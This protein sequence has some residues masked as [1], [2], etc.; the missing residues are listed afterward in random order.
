MVTN[1]GNYDVTM[2][3]SNDKHFSPLKDRETKGIEQSFG[4][5]LL[6]LFDNVNQKETKSKEL[7]ELAIVSPEEVNVHEVMIAEEEARLS[8]LFVKTVI[9]K[10]ITAWKDIM[11]LR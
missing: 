8:L 6:K 1:V 2:K 4:E 10:G 3:Y 5:L 9:D 7:Q 11:N